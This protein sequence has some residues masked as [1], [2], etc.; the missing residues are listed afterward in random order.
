MG[1]VCP[2]GLAQT[3]PR[4]PGPHC[5]AL[6]PGPFL[7]RTAPDSAVQHRPH[8]MPC[9]PLPITAPHNINNNSNRDLLFSNLLLCFA[10]ARHSSGVHDLGHDC[11]PEPGL[12]VA[13]PPPLLLRAVVVSG[14]TF[15]DRNA[16]RK[17]GWLDG[18][19]PQ[20][21]VTLQSALGTTL[22]TARTGTDGTYSFSIS[23]PG[24][25][26][27]VFDAPPGYKMTTMAA[28][29][30]SVTAIPGP[31]PASVDAG[32]KKSLLAL[33]LQRWRAMVG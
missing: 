27:I 2:V 11:A 6:D 10:C 13:A 33:F 25:Y 19:L 5:T 9:T 7:H 32:F 12:S 31:N 3:G 17:Q 30:F 16:N 1:S 14:K 21:Q 29:S 18:P 20:V 8:R 23:N 24:T 22:A 15:I 28:G 4:C 26:D